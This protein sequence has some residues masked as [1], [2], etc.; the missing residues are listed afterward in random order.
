MSNPSDR[1]LRTPPTSTPKIDPIEPQLF[2]PTDTTPEQLFVAIGQLRKEARDEINRLIAF[3]DKTDD[4]VS[5]ELE[6]DGTE[7][8]QDDELE[9]DGGDEPSLGSSGHADGGAISY[10]VRAISDGY[11]MIYDCEGDEHDGC[12]PSSDDEPSLCGRAD[13]AGVSG[14]DQDLEGERADDEPSLGWTID[15][16]IGRT[17][18]RACDLEATSGKAVL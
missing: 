11:E 8:E 12:E 18:E 10:F 3:L 4:Y 5:R 13:E 16:E 2:Y 17:T 15:G 14:G 6:P 1:V 9:D 7:E